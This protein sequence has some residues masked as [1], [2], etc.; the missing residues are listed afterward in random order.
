M[1]MCQFCKTVRR[2]AKGENWDKMM[3]KDCYRLTGHYMWENRWDIS[4]YIKLNPV[5]LYM[6]KTILLHD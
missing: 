5:D 2:K 4:D 1:V 3:C 6:T